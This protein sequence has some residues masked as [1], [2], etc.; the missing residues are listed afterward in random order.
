MPFWLHK[1]NWRYSIAINI[2]SFWSHFNSFKNTNAV[3]NK[4]T[5]DDCKVESAEDVITMR[6]YI[7]LFFFYLQYILAS[8]IPELDFV[9]NFTISQYNTIATVIQRRLETLVLTPTKQRD[10]MTTLLVCWS[11]C[12][13]PVLASH[14]AIRFSFLLALRILPSVI[15]R[16]GYVVP[17]FKSGDRGSV[18]NYTDPK[19]H[20]FSD[21]HSAHGSLGI[22]YRFIFTYGNLST[23]NNGFPR[24]S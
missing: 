16:A 5:L 8:Y 18:K 9:W 22:D 14:L 10:L 24:M 19:W 7:W 6:T 13:A 11:T 2:K 21:W 12:C 3:L 4:T 1:E 17:T 15:K 23:L 20:S